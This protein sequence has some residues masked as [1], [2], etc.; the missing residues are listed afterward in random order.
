VK[1]EATVKKMIAEGFD[2]LCKMA[3]DSN[4][5]LFWR[6]KK[7]GERYQVLDLV[8]LEAD[9]DVAVTYKKKGGGIKWVRPLDEFIDRFEAVEGPKRSK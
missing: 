9:L 4:P 1:K 5:Y 3:K 8:V 7:T 2:T 6:H